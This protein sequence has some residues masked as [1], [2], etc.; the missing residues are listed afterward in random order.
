VLE[1]IST[2]TTLKV[3][4]KVQI[5]LI[6]KAD[7]DMDLAHFKDIRASCMEPL[8]VLSGHQYQDGLSYY[9]T[10]NDAA[11]NYYFQQMSK[12]SYVV[13]YSAYITQSGNFNGGLSQIES[14][15]APE[16]RAHCEGMRLQMK[17]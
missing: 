16:I 7:R 3:G 5:R 14:L 15:Y 13:T 12:G 4:D 6:V 9:S 1:P 11:V 10:V 2:N 17:K 8:Q